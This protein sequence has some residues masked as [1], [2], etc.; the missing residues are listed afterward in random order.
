MPDKG[1]MEVTIAKV[2]KRLIPF[3][4]LMYVLSFLDR[5]NVGFA[6]DALQ[7]DTGLT[8]AM[9]AFGAG[10]FFLG[11]A[12][13]EIPSN[14]IMHRVGA[15]AWMCRI[16]VT[17]GM[18][19][20]AMMFAKTETTFYL[21][22]FLLG[23]AEA[24]FFPGV[25]LYLTYWFPSN[26]RHRALGLFYF[27]APVAFIVGGPLSGQLLDLDGFAGLRGWQWMF[28][29]EGLLAS[30]TGIWAFWYLDNKPADAAWLNSKEKEILQ[31]EINSEEVLKNDEGPKS[32]LRCLADP[33][34]LSFCLI[35]FLIQV[36]FYGVV[37]YLPTQVANLSGKKVGL[38]VG[39]LTAIPWIC[40]LTA[41][42]WIPRL[43]HR[44]GG[45]RATAAATLIIGAAGIAGS[46][47]AS[48][49]IFA[50][51]ALCIAA[52]G[53]IAPQP[54]FWTFPTGYLGGIA[55]AGGIALINSLGNLGGFAAPNLRIWMEETLSSKS[56][57][58]YTLAL[59]ALLSALLIFILKL[60]GVGKVD[61]RKGETNG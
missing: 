29:V 21:L 24:G 4:L 13:F 34:V 8:N 3:L 25:I 57:G 32:M 48:Y 40:A 37:Y 35:Y 17:W 16:M 14:L 26:V 55:A 50:F 23:V 7:V 46:A 30:V 39:L 11:Y 12:I 49:P 10:I 28:L 44:F 59:S 27:G 20:S 42:Y 58:L 33:V 36:S 56:A 9:F 38:E 22:R 47:A 43:S 54:L 53:I 2:T 51:I 61:N 18:V 6:K 5:A 19:S 52:A 1:L 41:A 60:E 45:R 15:R 31:N